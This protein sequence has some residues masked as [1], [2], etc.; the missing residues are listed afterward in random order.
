MKITI[1]SL[2]LT[3]TILILFIICFPK[4]S[5]ISGVGGY[6]TPIRIEDFLVAMMLLVTI[7]T[8]YTRRDYYLRLQTIL[9]TPV[10]RL[11]ILWLGVVAISTIYN[12][13]FSQSWVGLL[14]V[15]RFIEYIV[16]FF[17]AALFTRSWYSVKVAF[18]AVSFSSIFISLW[19][20]L[21]GMGFIGGFGGGFYGYTYIQGTDRAFASFSGPYELAGFLIMVIPLLIGFCVVE[22]RLLWRWVYAVSILL[23]IVALGFSGS[24]LPIIAGA[25]SI[26][27]FLLVRHD[28]RFSILIIAV[29]ILMVVVPP[30]VSKTL[31]ERYGLFTQGVEN[32]SLR[33]KILPTAIPTVTATPIPTS[34][35]T[36]TPTVTPRVTP[37]LSVVTPQPTVQESVPSESPVPPTEPSGITNTPTETRVSTATPTLAPVVTVT[38]VI[39]EPSITTVPL[40][41]SIIDAISEKD[42]SFGWR[43]QETWPRAFNSL[44]DNWLLGSGMG[45]LGVGLDGEFITLLGETGVIGLALFGLLFMIIGWS[46]ITRI[47]KSNSAEMKIIIAAVGVMVIALCINGLFADIFRAS[48]V[49][50]L[51]WFLLGVVLSHEDS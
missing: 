22:R 4:I 33:E 8:V 5:V 19:A 9:K 11:I 25:I 45:S 20:I 27:F 24:R 21:Q 34:I 16:F 44:S 35:P 14:F 2:Q 49:A 37:F 40:V 31:V 10:A 23:S 38:P 15:L 6:P 48:K 39:P 18:S 7:Y 50:M 12:S 26:P 51:L 42:T 36:A 32:I 30:L 47:R 43:L 41:Q 28:K 1:P 3:L 17:C 29:T 13:L 46:L